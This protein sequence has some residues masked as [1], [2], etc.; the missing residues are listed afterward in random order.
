[1]AIM[2]AA[3]FSAFAALAGSAIGALGGI[4]TT[5]L[6]L[7]SQERA[8][9][10]GQ[11]MSR[12]ENL[13][14]QFI[15]EASKLLTHAVGHKLE[16][17]SKLV[18][19]YALVNKLRLFAPSSVVSKADEVMRQLVQLHENTEKDFHIPIGAEDLHDLDVLRA[20]ADACRKDLASSALTHS[21]GSGT[22]SSLARM[23]GA[24]AVQTK[25]LGSALCSAR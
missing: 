17:L 22:L 21:D 7:N 3:Y 4:I 8:R 25:G 18:P 2:N 23:E 24:E 20:F 15:E 5:W 6:T 12:K 9:R 19:L 10:L 14:G 11:A 16:D 1:M 13:Y